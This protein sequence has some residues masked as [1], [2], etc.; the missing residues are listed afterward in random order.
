MSVI[1]YRP[2]VVSGNIDHDLRAI[3]IIPNTDPPVPPVPPIP[4]FSSGGGG[5]C[6]NEPVYDIIN[7]RILEGAKL[8]NGTYVS[9][10]QNPPPNLLDSLNILSLERYASGT[11]SSISVLDNKLAIVGSLNILFWMYPLTTTSLNK[12]ISIFT[13]GSLNSFGEYTCQ[14]ATDRRLQFSYTYS[15]GLNFTM[16]TI[17]QIL[18]KT[19]TFVSIVKTQNIVY[20]YINGKLDSQQSITTQPAATNNPLL[21]GT[22][23]NTNNFEGYLDNFIIN[24]SSDWSGQ[25]SKYFSYFPNDFLYQF[26]NGKITFNGYNYFFSNTLIQPT[27]IENAKSICS[28]LENYTNGF[29]YNSINNDY[30][31]Y[32]SFESLSPSNILGVPIIYN[33][34]DVLTVSYNIFTRLRIYSETVTNTNINDPILMNGFVRAFTG[35]TFYFINGE[36]YEYDTISNVYTLIPMNANK[37]AY[38]LLAISECIGYEVFGG[39]YK[40]YTYASGYASNN[41][42]FQN[43]LIKKLLRFTLGS[44]NTV[45]DYSGISEA[46][47]WTFYSTLKYL[48]IG[49]QPIVRHYESPKATDV[50][51][52]IIKEN[53]LTPIASDST[54]KISRNLSYRT[55]ISSIVYV[56]EGINLMPNMNRMSDFYVNQIPTLNKHYNISVDIDKEFDIIDNLI[57]NKVQYD[58]FIIIDL[59]LDIAPGIYNISFAANSLISLNVS[60]RDYK[61]NSNIPQHV[62]IHK[63]KKILEIQIQLYWQRINQIA[64]F[65]IVGA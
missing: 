57:L 1:S 8:L 15:N 51:S 11:Q 3:I 6:C 47:T 49:N 46:G 41:G 27:S 24:T 61:I 23:Y 33:K 31:F 25:I 40:F 32:S 34:I 21:I 55:E 36:A 17:Q 53:I 12:P 60:G 28:Q 26:I 18:E 52:E 63:G 48:N 56:Y 22:G 5:S 10:N 2:V 62:V 14:I 16:K 43:I 59:E 9:K 30:I 35:E 7:G 65:I 19:L 50:K 38:L 20:I 39:R 13:K 54:D 58:Q 44:I 29:T 4:T 64:K 37:G 42:T 45:V